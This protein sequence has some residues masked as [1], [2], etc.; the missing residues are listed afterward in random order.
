MKLSE[1]LG[2]PETRTK[3]RK[4]DSLPDDDKN[5]QNEDYADIKHSPKKNRTSTLNQDNSN[6]DGDKHNSN[7][8]DISNSGNQHDD[9]TNREMKSDKLLRNKKTDENSTELISNSMNRVDESSNAS[10]IQSATD[11]EKVSP[12]KN[13]KQKNN[14][15]QNSENVI[16]SN[17]D[18][19]V[20]SS[21]S[22]GVSN[23]NDA[24]QTKPSSPKKNEKEKKI[25]KI[26]DENSNELGSLSSSTSSNTTNLRSVNTNVTD[27]CE[28]TEAA[29]SISS[30]KRKKKKNK[31]NTD[32]NESESLSSSCATNTTDSDPNL[33]SITDAVCE[34][35]ESTENEL[36]RL[37]KKRKKLDKN[38][39]LSERPLCAT[40]ASENTSSTSDLQPNP[41]ENIPTTSDLSAKPL[42][43]CLK[44][45]KR[46]N[47]KKKN[48][49]SNDNSLEDEKKLSNRS[50]SFDSNV[51]IELIE[52][53]LSKS[54]AQE[55][56]NTS[57]NARKKVKALAYLKR[58]KEDKQN[59]KF[60]K[61]TQLWL[62]KNMFNHDLVSYRAIFLPSLKELQLAINSFYF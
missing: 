46:R 50:V 12:K 8:N 42:K 16:L 4:R 41:S 47:K 35:S 31:L 59:W 27:G 39:N 14:T 58:W 37:R 17:N 56:K 43:S 40:Y 34:P 60:E 53:C 24:S 29:E 55:E 48:Q 3:K 28:L 1:Q 20:L 44:K 15:N 38:S 36:P 10:C 21:N 52:N 33:C 51:K 13:R 22:L 49:R 11:D 9:K 54:L 57:V 62:L 25:N 32:F 6:S 45:K 23:R 26:N 2:S 19:I 7:D 61:L 18:S 5:I 30:K